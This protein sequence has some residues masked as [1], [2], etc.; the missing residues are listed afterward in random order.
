MSESLLTVKIISPE[1]LLYEGQAQ[2]VSLPGS[3]APFVVLAN[4]APIISTLDKGVVR[5]VDESL[6][7]HK[8]EIAGGVVRVL[9]NVVTICAD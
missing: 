3:E 7:E 9:K 4:H 5:I 2:R 8:I 6:K 1:S